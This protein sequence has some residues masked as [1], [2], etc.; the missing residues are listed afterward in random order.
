VYNSISKISS[1]QLP[2]GLSDYSIAAFLEIM[3]RRLH[4]Y[5]VETSST[6]FFFQDREG[7]TVLFVL[8]FS[9]AGKEKK[10]FS[11]FP[12]ELHFLHLI[13]MP[14]IHVHHPNGYTQ[15]IDQSASGCI[16]Q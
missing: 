15:V 7:F 13:L 12:N 14:S 10:A 2:V 8:F 9:F 4:A 1:N 3:I 11:I 16:I 5:H 6:S